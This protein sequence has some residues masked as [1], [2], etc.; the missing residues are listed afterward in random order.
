MRIGS[1]VLSGRTGMRKTIAKRVILLVIFSSASEKN[2]RERE[3]LTG[4][5]HTAYCVHCA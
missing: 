3:K 5:N 1:L 4:R 2:F